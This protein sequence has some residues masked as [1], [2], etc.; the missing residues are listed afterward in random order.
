MSGENNRRQ[1][2][3]SV[4]LCDFF[5]LC[6]R[7]MYRSFS[8]KLEI[9]KK[10]KVCIFYWALFTYWETQDATVKSFTIY[11]KMQDAIM[12]SGNFSEKEMYS[13]FKRVFVMVKIGLNKTESKFSPRSR[14]NPIMKLFKSGQISIYF[15]INFN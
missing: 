11:D 4:Y 2:V 1:C 8:R 3:E 14:A 7:S 9:V 12:N 6:K 5:T 10:A 13:T 15:N